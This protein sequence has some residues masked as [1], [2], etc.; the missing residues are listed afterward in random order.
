MQKNVDLIIDNGTLVTM[1]NRHRVLNNHS[2]AI[3]GMYIEAIDTAEEIRRSY[4]APDILDAS[5]MVVMP[6]LVDTY[7]HAGHGMIKGIYDPDLGWPTHELYFHASDEQWWHA[8]ALLSGLERLKFGVTTGLTVVGATPARMDSPVFGYKQAEAIAALGTRGVVAVGPPDPFYSHLSEPWSATLRHEGKATRHTF[9]F[10]DAMANTEA[11]IKDCSNAAGGR[12]RTAVHYPYLLGRQAAHPRIPFEYKDEYIPEIIKRAGEIRELA[13]RYGVIIHSH[14]FAGSIEYGL[15]KLGESVVERLLGSDVVF[16]HCNGFS[17]REIETLGHFRVN[18]AVVPFTHEN[19]YYGICPVVELL[20]SG[21]NVTISTDGT[22]PYASYNLWRDISRA[23]WDQWMK[24]RD[25]K[26]LP[27]GKALRMVTIDAARALGMDEHIG[28]LETGKK[29]D[30]ILLNMSQPHLFP[31]LFLPR[32]LALYAVGQDVDTVIVDGKV[33]MKGRKV[34]SVIEE[35]IIDQARA[36]N[37]QALKH[38]DVTRYIDMG[39]EFW[40][41]W[42]YPNN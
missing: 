5:K 40:T 38:C 37:E 32:L 24:H 23:I 36:A 42:R 19:I 31:D 11:V 25:Q 18:I 7:G 28:S 14:A 27:F 8:E 9:T 39:E 13:D 30:L 35:D 26:L 3:R 6:G 2:V 41:G 16:C 1:D 34:L 10:E 21:A 4:R 33:L 29:A 22:A 17:E 15:D 20:K 12:V